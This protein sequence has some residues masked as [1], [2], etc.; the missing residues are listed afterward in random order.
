M[1]RVG[2][3]YVSHA[4]RIK[5][6]W[7]A[8]TAQELEKE[9]EPQW[10]LIKEGGKPMEIDSYT[11]KQ[12][13]NGDWMF[14][15]TQEGKEKPFDRLPGT[16]GMMS[17]KDKAAVIESI[18]YRYQITIKERRKVSLVQKKVT[19]KLADER[20]TGYVLY[21]KGTGKFIYRLTGSEIKV[22]DNGK[23]R[24]VIFTKDDLECIGN[25]DEFDVKEIKVSKVKYVKRKIEA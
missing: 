13:K 8:Q 9:S 17:E 7:A 12:D 16:Y 19:L 21:V 23:T 6:F 4:E 25:I 3:T 11:I 1:A 2:K 5:E 20:P 14:Y 24:P 18:F 15:I 10:C 22:T